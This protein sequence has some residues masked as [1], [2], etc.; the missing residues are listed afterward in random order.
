MRNPEESHDLERLARRIL[1]AAVASCDA[2]VAVETSVDLRGD[3]LHVAGATVDLTRYDEIR[4]AAVG[5]ASI[6]M[7]DA[8]GRILDEVPWIAIRGLAVSHVDR[9]G[10]G[11]AWAR[12][13]VGSHPLPDSRSFEAGRAVLELFDGC[14]PSTLAVFLLSG[15]GS[16]LAEWPLDERLAWEDLARLNELLT[17]SS[18]PIRSINAVRKHLSAIKGGRLAQRAM[19]ADQLT[20]LISD[21]APGDAQSVASGPT[22]PDSTTVDEVARA[23][24]ES[25]LRAK[26]SESLRAALASDVLV[27]TPKGADFATI[28]QWV[29]M[30][31][32]SAAAAES[33]RRE[34]S[35]Y[36]ERLEVR[37]ADGP[38]DRVVD[39]HLRTL[40][41]LAG[42]TPSGRL[43]AIIAA[44]EVTLDVTGDGLGG[45]NQHTVL[46]ALN[47]VREL[48]PSIEEFALLS[49]GTDGRDGPTDAAGAVAS[50]RTLD[51]ARSRGLDLESYLRRCD[52]YHFFEPL[53]GLVVTGAT[54]TNVRDVRVFLGKSAGR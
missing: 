48:C 21:V 28:R 44:G 13:L 46:H 32:D 33:A 38:L 26:L 23:L 2:E 22:V 19:P 11:P 7:L 39:D 8:F 35:K 12:T 20:L 43:C 18:L 16:A 41:A 51:E 6:G 54:R 14:T 25:G 9:V 45:R 17:R 30:V 3:Q 29:G 52:S 36:V 53:D 40:Q 4:V 24:D 37:L 50:Q 5:K 49:A 15:G 31:L 10:S 34:A 1:L 47:R 27:E 42:E